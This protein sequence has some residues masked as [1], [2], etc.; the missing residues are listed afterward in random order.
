MTSSVRAVAFAVLLL[1]AC[2]DASN[3][4]QPGSTASPDLVLSSASS[5]IIPG[6]YIVVFKDGVTDPDGLAQSLVSLYGG[7]LKHT[8]KS[9]LKGF[10]AILSDAAVAALQAQTALV[11]YIEPDQK[12]GPDPG[13]QP[14]S[15]TEQM[16]AN[17]DPWGLDRIEIGRAHV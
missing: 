4:L 17:G 12:G 6:Q 13:T 10:A 9:G 11:D 7:T 8:Y 2:R 1:A 5:N 16:D 14:T 15:Q 3:P